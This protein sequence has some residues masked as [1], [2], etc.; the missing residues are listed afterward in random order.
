MYTEI[1][2]VKTDSPQNENDAAHEPGFKLNSREWNENVQKLAAM[3]GG[4][5]ACSGR[6]AAC[7]RHFNDQNR[8]IKPIAGRRG[9]L[10]RDSRYQEIQRPLEARYG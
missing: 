4:P 10:L 5:R 6:R 1:E 2:L 8:S 7:E 3:F 9:T